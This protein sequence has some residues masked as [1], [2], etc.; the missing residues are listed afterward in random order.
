MNVSDNKIATRGLDVV[1]Y[2]V[3]DM[4]RARAFYEALFDLRVG[5]E[6]EYWVEYELPDGNTFALGND[7]VGGWHEG[8]GVMFGVPS[9]DE[10]VERAVSLGGRKHERDFDSPGCRSAAVIDTE[11]NLLLLHQRK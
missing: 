5:L 3:K 11:D 8:N 10:A 2:L 7:P 1:F 4:K 9:I 6:S